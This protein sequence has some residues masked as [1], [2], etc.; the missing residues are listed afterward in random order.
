MK[1]FKLLVVD[2]NA[3]Q[4]YLMIDTILITIIKSFHIL[5]I[6]NGTSYY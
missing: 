4:I 3:E 6:K 5:I 2:N 1:K